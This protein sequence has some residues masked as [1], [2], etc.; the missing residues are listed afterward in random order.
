[1]NKGTV[2]ALVVAVVGIGAIILSGRSKPKS[3]APP[4]GQPQT[5]PSVVTGYFDSL[6]AGMQALANSLSPQAG[7]A[8]GTG[9][10]GAPPTYT[11]STGGQPGYHLN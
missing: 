10:M 8:N 2:I 4:S 3:S 9:A 1:M 6:S 5:G 11:L 7:S